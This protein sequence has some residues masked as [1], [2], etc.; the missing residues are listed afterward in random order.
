MLEHPT[1]SLLVK[2]CLLSDG[3][4]RWVGYCELLPSSF[5]GPSQLCIHIQLTM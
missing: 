3:D 5:D 4:L 2:E 1:V